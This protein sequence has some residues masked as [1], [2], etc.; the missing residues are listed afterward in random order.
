MVIQ[1]VEEYPLREEEEKGNAFNY[2]LKLVQ[3]THSISLLSIINKIEKVPRGIQGE[4]SSK[5]YKFCHFH[6]VHKV[7]FCIVI[8]WLEAGRAFMAIGFIGSFV[9]AVCAG[10]FAWKEEHRE[11]QRFKKGFY[12][13]AIATGNSYFHKYSLPFIINYE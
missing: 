7:C 6:R 10:L 9:V 2:P 12:L 3:V 4:K 11:N 5:A 8:G 1:G 13:C